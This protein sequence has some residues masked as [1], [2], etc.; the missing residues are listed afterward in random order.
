MEPK[1]SRS[2]GFDDSAV[3]SFSLSTQV[4]LF[5][6]GLFECDQEAHGHGDHQEEAGNDGLLLFEGMYC[7]LPPNVQ[8]LLHLQQAHR[9]ESHDAVLWGFPKDD[10]RALL[11]KQCVV[12]GLPL[13]T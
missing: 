6:A 11:V 10:A 1:L 8:Q 4:C 12:V 9:C 3:F 13:M 5:S 2:F 7:R